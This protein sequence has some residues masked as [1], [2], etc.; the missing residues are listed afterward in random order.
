MPDEAPSVERVA[1]A[2]GDAERYQVEVQNLANQQFLELQS[3]A[4]SLLKTVKGLPGVA[5][6]ERWDALV[7][8]ACK[9][10]PTGH[11]LLN[12]MGAKRY[13]DPELMAVLLHIRQQLLVDIENPTMADHLLADSVIVSYRHML[14]IQGWID[15][16]CLT[17]ERQL[18]GQET[19]Q[20]NHGERVGNRIEEQI[21]DLENKLMPL[22]H[23]SQK[24]LHSAL[25]KLENRSK[26][27]IGSVAVGKAGQVNIGSAVQNNS[28]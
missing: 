4:Q 24:M 16:I 22:L 15:S 23:R 14:R 26:R 25:A 10:Y 8:N 9:D 17:V 3:Q 12:R 11:F 27:T 6:Q 28:A 5:T 7:E 19:L 13:L 1:A 18:F 21:R 20:E 2:A